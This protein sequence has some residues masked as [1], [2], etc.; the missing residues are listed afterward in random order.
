MSL[1]IHC[2]PI[3]KDFFSS[4][5]RASLA[6]RW[7][8]LNSGR[9]EDVNLPANVDFSISKPLAGWSEKAKKIALISL[10][11]IFFPWSLY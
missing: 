8:E 7:E 4:S 2:L 10:K 1:I 5:D 9:L 11:T 3:Y 6:L